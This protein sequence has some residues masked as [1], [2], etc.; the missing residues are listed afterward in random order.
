MA[1]SASTM[2]CPVCDEQTLQTLSTSF[3]AW[4]RCSQCQGI[5]IRQDLVVA[6]STDRAQS[7]AALAETKGLL[8]PAD[9][10]CPKCLQKLFDGRV[11]SR[12]VILSLCPTCE[13]LWT[14]LATLRQF[15]AG[16]EKK[17]AEETQ[18][19][20]IADTELSPG[21]V[22][23]SKFYEDSGM[24]SFFRAFARLFDKVADSF[25]TDPEEKELLKEAKRLKKQKGKKEPLPKAPVAP[26][27]APPAPA[28]PEKLIQEVQPVPP[29]PIKPEVKP[30]APTEPLSESPRI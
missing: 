29:A 4:E 25:R 15:E 21:G 24:A 30:A 17:L 16:I 12:G 9:R 7:A 13:S 22:R 26:A 3:G 23:R 10:T 18:A 27:K 20:G 5:F 6:A 8:L 1:V 2:R 11:E 28:K 14:N 19:S